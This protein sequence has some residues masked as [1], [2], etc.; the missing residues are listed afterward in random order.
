MACA[1]ECSTAVERTL[2]ML[3]LSVFLCRV[4]KRRVTVSPR[5]A[6]A[7]VPVRSGARHRRTAARATGTVSRSSL[8]PCVADA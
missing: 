4:F 7:P 8:T 6:L 3:N 1:G 2:V 5:P